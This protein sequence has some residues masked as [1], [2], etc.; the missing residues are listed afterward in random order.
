M[1]NKFEKFTNAKK[2][3]GNDVRL[4][5]NGKFIN[6]KTEI[7]NEKNKVIFINR[8]PDGEVQKFTI[9]L[10]EKKKNYILEDK[11]YFKNAVLELKNFCEKNKVEISK[12]T[13]EAIHPNGEKNIAIYDP[14]KDIITQYNCVSDE[15][16]EGLSKLEY[17]VHD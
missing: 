7:I 5:E 9:Y 13:H 15:N 11:E 10:K 3:D 12:T 14:I 2:F 4:D 17:K 1:E 8:F 6:E 16:P